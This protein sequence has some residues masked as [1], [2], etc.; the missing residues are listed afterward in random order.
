MCYEPVCY[1]ITRLDMIC[2]V[3]QGTA[4]HSEHDVN[5]LVRT[6]LEC[7]STILGNKPFLLGCNPSEADASLFGMLDQFVYG[8]M[9]SKEM[10]EM[11]QHFPNLCQFTE[12]IRV[13][14][15]PETLEDMPDAARQDSSGKVA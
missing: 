12:R 7:L 5:V 10:K 2:M 1:M 13:R 6:H 3:M 11:I 4:R 8:C 9:V 14:F 15:F